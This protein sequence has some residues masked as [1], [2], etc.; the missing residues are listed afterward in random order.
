[1]KL[2]KKVKIEL[3]VLLIL[4]NLILRY[5]ITH[6]EIF[7]DSFE[8]H[9]LAN[10]LSEFGEARWWVHPLSIIG[11]YPNSYAS[12]ISFLL[13]GISQC[14]G[15]D[16]ELII[17]IYGLIFGLFSMFAGYIVAGEI[18]DNDLFKFLVAFGFSTCQGILT[19]TTWTAPARSPFI[20]LL[21][22]FLYALLKSRKHLLRF[23]LITVILSLLLLA[24]HHM[25]FYLIPIFAAC[26]LVTLVYK[27]KEHIN[28]IKNLIKKSE[29]LMPLFIISGFCLMLAYPFMTHKF[30]TAGSRWYNL[31]LMFNEYP[32]YIGILIFL[33]IGGF[34][35]LVFKPA[36]RYEEWSLLAMLMFLTVFIFQE[37]Y[38]KWFIIIFAILLAGVG[39]MN[40]NKLCEDKKKKKHATFVIII[41]LLL[42][43][44]FSGYFQFLH[45]Y[46]T[47]PGG[48]KRY[49]EYSEYTTGLWIK[50]NMNG[51]GICNDRWLGWRIG[52][53]SGFPLLTGSSSNDQAYGFVDAREFE[54]VKYPITSE[55][56]WLQS[57]Y[58]RVVGTPSDEYWQG[59]MSRYDSHKAL[60]LIY[61]FNISYLIENRRTQGG[62]SSHRGRGFGQSAFLYS[63]HE[64]GEKDC[65][66]DCGNT[67]VWE[68]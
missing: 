42:S 6:H 25:A 18:Y 12:M 20:I 32:R 44:S 65:I 66:Y 38:T 63:I 21:P 64:Y 40:L 35:Y 48:L 29:N 50:E 45:E 7:P 26:F 10:S 13:S 60:G 22:L 14:T 27:L 33:A 37:M 1:M 28:V 61:S 56:F 36:K 15:L 5:S 41:F 19:Y 49:M 3:F 31:A 51:K 2:P 34:A 30:M 11:M 58:W 8:M 4:L 52:A 24:I 59:I 55:E 9:M 54:L 17:V 53:T 57:P 67:Y 47:D 46:G 62:W 23:G 16:I 39:F 68:L 43:V